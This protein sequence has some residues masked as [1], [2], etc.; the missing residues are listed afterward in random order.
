M[1]VHVFLDTNVLLDFYSYPKDE[2]AELSRLRDEVN[3]DRLV[4]WSTQ[5]VV[6]ELFR[7]RE[8]KVQES[9]RAL[10]EVVRPSK[11]P[12]ILGAL[13]S[14]DEFQRVRAELARTSGLMR[15]ELMR[16]LD[17]YRLNADEAI[18]GL[19]G[20]ATIVERSPVIL[21]RARDRMAVGNPPGKNGSLGDAI[22]WECL[23]EACP[24][25]DICIVTRDSDFGSPVDS[26]RLTEFLYREWT[27]RK[28]H[29]AVLYK[30]LST[31]FKVRVPEIEFR[32]D[33]EQDVLVQNLVYA[34]TFAAT[35]DAIE[36]LA[37][38][39]Q[40]TPSQTGLLVKALVENSQIYMIKRDPDVRR[41]YT[42]FVEP[43]LEELP[44]EY[45]EMFYSKYEQ[46]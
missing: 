39:E 16:Q 25:Q 32:V 40:L 26:D 24:E 42:K 27:D 17:T 18:D 9:M 15:K 2:I 3:N 36:R 31:F 13:D 44:E 22:N 11:L 20:V 30:R 7:K 35:H 28:H 38:T 33:A 14:F 46:R 5:Q 21:S 34:D 8:S 19:L 41:F 29:E 43:A 4:L 37:G 6:E 10:N 23:L 12:T 1:T 45:S